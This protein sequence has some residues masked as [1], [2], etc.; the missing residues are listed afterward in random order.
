M[1]ESIQCY[2][3]TML[4]NHCLNVSLKGLIN[5]PRREYLVCLKRSFWVSQTAFPE[6]KV[7]MVW[8]KHILLVSTKGLGKLRRK[9]SLAMVS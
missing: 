5:F 7:V 8:F 1:T 4:P 9:P 6:G 2:N 3:V